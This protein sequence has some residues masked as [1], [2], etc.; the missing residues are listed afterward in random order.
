MNLYNMKSVSEFVTNMEKLG[1]VVEQL[2]DGCQSW[3]KVLKN[4]KKFIVSAAGKAEKAA[5]L[6]LNI[7]DEIET[8][9]VE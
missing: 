8:A 7:T 3:L 5:K 9:A 6:I 4:D 2:N 1:Y